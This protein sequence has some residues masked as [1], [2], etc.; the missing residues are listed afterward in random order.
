MNYNLMGNYLEEAFGLTEFYLNDKRIV[1]T[2]SNEW[3]EL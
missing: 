1:K 2:T 3:I